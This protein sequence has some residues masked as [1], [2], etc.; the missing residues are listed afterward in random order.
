MSPVQQC[1]TIRNAFQVYTCSVDWTLCFWG[2][3]HCFLALKLGPWFFSGQAHSCKEGKNANFEYCGELQCGA[4]ILLQTFG[5][6]TSLPATFSASMCRSAPAPPT[7]L[8]SPPPHPSASLFVDK[9]TAPDESRY[10]RWNSLSGSIFIGWAPGLI[11]APGGTVSFVFSHQCVWLCANDKERDTER[12]GWDESWAL[13]DC[14]ETCVTWPVA[15]LNLIWIE[16]K[17]R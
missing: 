14:T 13:R 3:L 12:S 17:H 15:N 11:L 7:P 8:T 10:Q 5:L 4:D 9:N 6:F 16:V 1:S 2:C